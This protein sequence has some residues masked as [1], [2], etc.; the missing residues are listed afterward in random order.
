VYEDEESSWPHGNNVL[1]APMILSAIC[2]NSYVI[3]LVGIL[4]RKIYLCECLALLRSGFAS[5]PFLLIWMDLLER[6]SQL[7]KW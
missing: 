7:G 5:S 2:A 6:L 4:V 3:Y 1:C